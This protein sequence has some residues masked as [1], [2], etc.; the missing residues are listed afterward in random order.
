MEGDAL[1]CAISLTFEVYGGSG[2]HKDS[3]LGQLLL[4]A[5]GALKR[6][7]MTNS[8]HPLIILRRDVK[9]RRHP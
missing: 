9:V 6:K 1:A 5:I 3:G 7:K 8:G 4:D 2:N